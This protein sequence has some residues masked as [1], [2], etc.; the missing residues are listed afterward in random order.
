MHFGGNFQ[1]ENLNGVFKECLKKIDGW[2]DKEN[3]LVIHIEIFIGEKKG[4]GSLKT[5]KQTLIKILDFLKIKDNYTDDQIEK[6]RLN[7]F[8]GTH[9]FRSG[10]IDSWKTELSD[11]MIKK[12]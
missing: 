12:N 2:F 7:L 8:G 10:K 11:N 1:S 9:T 4:G 3:V 5:Q 6:I